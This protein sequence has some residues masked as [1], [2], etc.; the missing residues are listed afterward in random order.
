MLNLFIVMPMNAG[1]LATALTALGIAV[2]AFLFSA[3]TS[4]IAFGSSF[5]GN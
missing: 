2:V 3:I 4:R 1:A 5:K